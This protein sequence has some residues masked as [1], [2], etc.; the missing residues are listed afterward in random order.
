M[1]HSL[2]SALSV[3]ASRRLAADQTPAVQLL[4]QTVYLNYEFH[5][6]LAAVSISRAPLIIATGNGPRL[7]IFPGK[8]KFPEVACRG[9]F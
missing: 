9:A 7:S 5:S 6:T 8:L 4:I 2:R 1:Q 3:N